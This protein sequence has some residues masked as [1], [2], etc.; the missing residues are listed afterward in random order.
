MLG[1]RRNPS[2]TTAQTQTG[3]TSP[4]TSTTCRGTRAKSTIRGVSIIRDQEST[5]EGGGG[6]EGGEGEEG[7]GKA[8]VVSTAITKTHDHQLAAAKN[9]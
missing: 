6:G 5:T 3:K 9:R 8:E 1:N 2:R 4:A 7:G